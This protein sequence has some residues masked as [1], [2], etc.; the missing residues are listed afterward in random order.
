MQRH[1][2]DE[3]RLVQDAKVA[4]V[5]TFDRLMNDGDMS[6][7]LDCISSRINRDR[8]SDCLQSFCG[9]GSD[10]QDECEILMDIEIDTLNGRFKFRRL[11]NGARKVRRV[12]ERDA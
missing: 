9:V 10:A 7:L 1:F 11:T 5:H 4:K 2:I 12:G 6:Q 3:T 8:I